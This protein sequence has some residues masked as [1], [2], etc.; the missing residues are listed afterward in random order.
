VI[1]LS[2]LVEMMAVDRKRPGL[3]VVYSAEHWNKHNAECPKPMTKPGTMTTPLEN[4]HEKKKKII[5]PKMNTCRSYR[6]Y[7]AH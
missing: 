1:W 3:F 4:G 2:S 5:F 6:S 7:F